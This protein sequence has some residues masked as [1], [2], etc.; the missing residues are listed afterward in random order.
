MTEMPIIICELFSKYQ[1]KHQMKIYFFIDKLLEWSKI[2]QKCADPDTDTRRN[3]DGGWGEI[4]SGRLDDGETRGW[5]EKPI[6]DT[7]C[8]MRGIK[9]S[10]W[11]KAQSWKLP[12]TM[13][14]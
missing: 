8:G 6:R 7:K 9:H 12:P 14:L 10:A 5:G 2:G 13:K 3:G 4:I 11:R 1:I